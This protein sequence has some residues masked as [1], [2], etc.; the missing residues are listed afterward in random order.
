[1]K[2]PSAEVVTGDLIEIEK[3]Q[4]IAIDGILV[5]ANDMS[6]DEADLTGE[7]EA[8]YKTVVTDENKDVEDVCPFVF[9]GAVTKTGFGTALVTAVGYHTNSGKAD[10]AMEFEAEPTPLQTKLH[11]IATAV[12]YLGM[13]AAGATF[14]ALMV[15]L[16]LIIFVGEGRELSDP[17]NISA[18]LDA[19]II[20]IAITLMAVPEGLPL[21]VSIS[22]GFSV[23]DLQEEGNLVRKMDASETMGSIDQICTDKTG[24][25]TANVMTVQSFWCEDVV[26]DADRTDMN[27]LASKDIVI[28]SIIYNSTA[29]MFEK[30]E[31]QVDDAGNKTGET[32][33]K[34]VEGNPTECALINYLVK[35]GVDALPLLQQK[36][37]NKDMFVFNTPFDSVRKEATLAYK[38]KD[39]GVRLLV[40]GAP[41]VVLPKCKYFS[42]AGG[43]VAEISPA[44]MDAIK[45]D[46]VIRR[47]A[48][49]AYRTLALCYK[50]FPQSEWDALHRRYNAF[51]DVKD[52][53]GLETDLTVAGIVGIS[54]PL[55]PGI[56]D[57]VI[58]LRGAGVT[59]RMVTGDNVETAT[60]ISKNAGLIS[61]D[62]ETVDDDEDAVT[63]EQRRKFTCMEGS[64]FRELVGGYE[65]TAEG[66][67]RIVNMHQFKT[68]VKYLRVMARSSPTDKYILVT[69]LR[70]MG[71]IV[72]VTGDGTNDAP[73]LA[74]AD[75]GLAMGTGSDAAK[76]ASKIVLTNDDFC[77]VVAAV[78]YGR[79]IYDSVRKF[80]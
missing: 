73:A 80:L 39:G 38:K 9:K 16:V 29:S 7:P 44:K 48:K 46:E 76:D 28:D 30:T 68:I 42:K 72:A 1:M 5:A 35:S 52:R 14:L 66:K 77:A 24:T 69:G 32:Q 17:E 62:F 8:R 59:T 63:R 55:R 47:Y 20:T 51:K 74:R 67:D 79:N 56:K 13:T 12:G 31:D 53:D 33:V 75:V 6:C 23:G 70:N 18:I 54:D 36:A 19:V 71:H 37:A 64:A 41:D 60:A 43:Q 26:R 10:H 57:A 40:K 27:A 4:R 2:I 21:A 22:L 65:R 49:Q 61:E 50:D 34:K 58:K 15:R 78:K 25:L 3:D 45:G 11:R